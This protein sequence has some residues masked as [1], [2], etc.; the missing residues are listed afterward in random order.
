M[1]RSME[2]YK[3]NFKNA[4]I[5]YIPNFFSKEEADLYLESLSKSIEF[6]KKTK[7]GRLT[8]LHGDA[9]MYKYALNEGI[10]KPWTSELKKIKDKIEEA[11]SYNYDVCLL[12]YYQNGKNGFRFHSDKEEIGN[13]TPICSI[14]FGAERKFYFRSKPDE[15]NDDLEEYNIVLDHGS[16]LIMGRG[17]HEN[18]IHGL[19]MDNKIKFPRLNL[20]FRKTRAI[21][22]PTLIA[23]TIVVNKKITQDYDVFIGRPSKWGNPF[24]MKTEDDREE[25]IK[26]YREWI[27]TQPQLLQD[28]NE[29]K[30]RR[31]ACY[32]KPL[33][34]HGDI[35]AELADRS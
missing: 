29:L 33:S 2:K 8:A 23:K 35:L 16:L 11:T 27:V 5:Y 3:L 17:T 32:C 15:K 22:N 20:T 6:E 18:Y 10:P 14:S 19:P 31:L 12:N 1:E 24:K 9:K 30:G 34:C 4:E 13:D 7:E 25:V 26:K 28:L 21:N